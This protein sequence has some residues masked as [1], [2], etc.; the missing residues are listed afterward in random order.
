[1]K[2]QAK[3]LF[4][5]CGLMFFATSLDAKQCPRTKLKNKQFVVQPKEAPE[6][7]APGAYIG[8]ERVDDIIVPKVG[9][10]VAY[11]FVARN[12][13]PDKK[14]RLASQNL[15]G[16]LQYLYAYD[17]DDDGSVGR[18]VPE[19][20][21]MLENEIF[22][23]FDFFKGQPVRYWLLSDD[24]AVRKSCQIVP[25]P[26]VATAQ[27]GARISIQRLT[28]DSR[29]VLVEGRDF[30]PDETVYI[31]TQSANMRIENV[32]M[33][34]R[35]GHFSMVVEPEIEGKSG[36]IAYV[37]VLR[38][39]ERLILDYEWGWEAINPKKRHSPSRAMDPDALVKLA[40]E[41]NEYS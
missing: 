20:T 17:V 39:H 3:L 1:M 15:G 32:K 28:P 4:L 22:L 33:P 38:A 21:L 18:Q 37:E 9:P 23:M 24:G 6:C 13:P 34:C 29:L 2:T 25:H 8:A 14:L 7:G 27:D 5:S 31:T 36:G 10:V 41:Q 12:F 11:R 35:K 40:Q 26:I 19:G 16:P 30:L